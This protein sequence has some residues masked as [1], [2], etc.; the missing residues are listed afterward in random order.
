MKRWTLST[1][2]GE[3][4]GFEKAD[5][6]ALRHAAELHDMGIVGIPGNLLTKKRR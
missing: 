5:L 3:R 4:M 1:R 2:I 6:S